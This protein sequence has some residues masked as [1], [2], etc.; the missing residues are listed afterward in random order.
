ML[1]CTRVITGASRQGMNG[2]QWEANKLLIKW[3]VFILKFETSLLF[4]K[5]GGMVGVLLPLENVFE[6]DQHVLTPVLGFFYFET[7]I[8]W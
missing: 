3:S 4:I 1:I 6:I 5:S 2:V 8:S 7:M